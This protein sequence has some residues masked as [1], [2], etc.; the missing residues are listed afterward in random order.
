M[1]TSGIVALVVLDDDL[2]QADMPELQHVS[3]ECRFTNSLY[4][5][6]YIMKQFVYRLATC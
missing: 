1:T 6:V 5:F 2:A 4:K 3:V